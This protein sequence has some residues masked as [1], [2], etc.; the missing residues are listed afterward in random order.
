M[1][2]RWDERLE[3][4]LGKKRCNVCGK[5]LQIGKI[6]VL[7]E[8]K[9]FH[10]LC[11]RKIKAE[12]LKEGKVDIDEVAENTEKSFDRTISKPSIGEGSS[13]RPRNE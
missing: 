3:E 6:F 8:R 12:H 5:K 10:E 13:L 4:I 1:S 9:F 11:Y 2:E 7:K